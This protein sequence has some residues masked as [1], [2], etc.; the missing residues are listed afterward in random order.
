ME[1]IHLGQPGTSFSK[2]L[3]W[4]RTKDIWSPSGPV[5]SYRADVNDG[6]L[7]AVLSRDPAGGGGSLLW[8]ISVSFRDVSGNHTRCP[9]WD[10]LKSAK[11]QLVPVDVPMILLFPMKSESYV[12]IH[13]TTLHL[14]GGRMTLDEIKAAALRT[15]ASGVAP[16]S[17]RWVDLD[18]YPVKECLL[19][20]A[21]DAVC[22][23][24]VESL[25]EACQALGID[26]HTAS[27]ITEGWDGR[28]WHPTSSPR[29]ADGYA[30]GIL[31]RRE[32]L[33]AP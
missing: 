20:A 10:E 5:R 30:F 3:R 23:V 8:H 21:A 1:Q 4:H 2:A 26:W 17:Q 14:W 19:S 6:V 24:P 12:N 15:Y 13:P 31:C 9:T 28:P 25:G 16:C 33:V 7:V 29:S 11:F 27:G 32:I 22:G 18:T